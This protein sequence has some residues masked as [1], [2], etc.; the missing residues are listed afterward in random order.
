M[1]FQRELI[2][3]EDSVKLRYGN[4]PEDSPWLWDHM[5]KYTQVAKRPMS[6]IMVFWGKGL[7]ELA[8]YLHIVACLTGEQSQYLVCNV[9]LTLHN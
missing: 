6:C 4:G 1:Y 7:I 3:W 5:K 8:L 9:E 2:V